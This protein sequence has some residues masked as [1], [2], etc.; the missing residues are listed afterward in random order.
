MS[1]IP[2]SDLGVGVIGKFSSLSIHTSVTLVMMDDT[3]VHMPCYDLIRFLR[4][5]GSDVG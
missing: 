5:S 3:K 4:V 1:Y 2:C